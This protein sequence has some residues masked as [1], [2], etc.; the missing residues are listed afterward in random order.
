MK[1]LILIILLFLACQSD[2]PNTGEKVQPVENEIKDKLI[3]INGFSNWDWVLYELCY[4]KKYYLV[5]VNSE[6]A[7]IEQTD[8]PCKN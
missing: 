8:K 2:T 4:N 1:R 7:A 6:K 3:K 5:I